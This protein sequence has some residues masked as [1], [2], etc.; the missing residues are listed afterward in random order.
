MGGNRPAYHLNRT[1][2]AAAGLQVDSSPLITGGVLVGITV[3]SVA[4]DPA[5][6]A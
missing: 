5:P 6:G 3:V 2:L 1:A 4:R